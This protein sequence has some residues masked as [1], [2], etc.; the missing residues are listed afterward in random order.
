MEKCGKRGKKYFFHIF[1]I[2]LKKHKLCP[3]AKFHSDSSKNE[4]RSPK[5]IQMGKVYPPLYLK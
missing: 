1:F 4:D 3:Y 5:C 2:S